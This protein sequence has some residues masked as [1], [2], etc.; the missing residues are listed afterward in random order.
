M[1]V[2]VGVGSSSSAHK[3]FCC[4]ML[5]YKFGISHVALVLFAFPLLVFQCLPS[6]A[7]AGICVV[8]CAFFVMSLLLF[9]GVFVSTFMLFSLVYLLP[10][11]SLSL[12]LL[13]SD[14]CGGA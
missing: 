10:F 9:L 8:L 1:S 5:S 7:P 12:S 4:V 3:H 13:V 14:L 2:S 6:P 11:R